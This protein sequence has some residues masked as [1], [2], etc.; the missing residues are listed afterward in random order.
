MST[1]NLFKILAEAGKGRQRQVEV[2]E[3]GEVGKAVGNV[4]SLYI[5]II[6]IY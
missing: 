4:P 6:K 2:E 3:V 1:F 5:I